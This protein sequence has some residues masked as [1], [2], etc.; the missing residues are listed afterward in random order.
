M[1]P[2]PAVVGAT[3]VWTVSGGLPTT[4]VNCN[5]VPAEY[6]DPGTGYGIGAEEVPGT[7]FHLQVQP[8]AGVWIVEGNMD[9]A[10]A[11]TA[12]CATHDGRRTSL[13]VV[14]DMSHTTN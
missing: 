2:G 5:T 7:T 14:G 13:I 3:A 8:P 11:T 10:G 1:S 9:T 12:P 4:L 6:P